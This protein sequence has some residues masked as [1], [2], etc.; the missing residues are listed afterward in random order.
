MDDKQVKIQQKIGETKISHYKY[1]WEES[2]YYREIWIKNNL[3][4]FIP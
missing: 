4:N 3:P 1:L 2:N